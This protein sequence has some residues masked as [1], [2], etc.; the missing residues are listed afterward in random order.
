MDE[1]PNCSDMVGNLLGKRKCFAYQSSN[2][3]PQ[4]VVEALDVIRF[5]TVFADN[6]MSL[7]R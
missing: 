3:L 7:V 5:A 2:P 6:S 4:G 1:V